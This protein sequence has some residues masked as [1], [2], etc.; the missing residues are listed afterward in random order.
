LGAGAS[1]RF[2][3]PTGAELRQQIID[4]VGM[5][6]NASDY[7]ELLERFRRSLVSS[8]DAF[9]AEKENHHLQE[10]GRVAIVAALPST[11]T[12]DATA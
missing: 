10:V 6:H 2:G 8:I 9:L 4:R 5:N 1:V 3:Y 12:S 11:R 7:R